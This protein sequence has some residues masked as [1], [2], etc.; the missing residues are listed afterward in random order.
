MEH[1]KQVKV[2]D[3]PVVVESDS[4][5]SEDENEDAEDCYDD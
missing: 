3:P 2:T 4:S 1:A 5:S